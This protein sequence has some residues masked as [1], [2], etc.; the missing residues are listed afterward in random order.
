MS[1]LA[2]SGLGSMYIF[3]KGLKGNELKLHIKSTRKYVNYDESQCLGAQ[4]YE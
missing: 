2:W 3:D 1:G 4:V